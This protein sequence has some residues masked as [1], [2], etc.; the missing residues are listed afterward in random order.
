MLSDSENQAPVSPL[1]LAVSTRI[2]HTKDFPVSIFN[3][4]QFPCR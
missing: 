3:E 4:V 1:H 2:C